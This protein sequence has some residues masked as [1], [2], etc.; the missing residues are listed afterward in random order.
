MRIGIDAR[1]LNR[2]HLRG[3]G[4][5]VKDLLA[6]ADLQ[7]RQ[8]WRLYGDRPDQP[9]HRPDV[10]DLSASLFETRGYRFRWWEQAGLPRAARR[11]RVEVLH[12]TGTTLPWWQPVP[13]VV[14]LHDTVP[15]VSESAG[16]PGWYLWQVLPRAYRKCAAVITISENSRRDILALW[17]DLEP[18]LL[19]IPHGID[20]RYLTE[21]SVALPAEL[22]QLGIRSPYLVYLGGTIPRKRLDWAVQVLSKLPD[23]R[24]QLVVCGVDATSKAQVL[25]AIPEAVRERVLVT[26]FIGEDAMPPLLRHGVALLY[27]T[28]Y[29][30]FGFPAIE[31]QAVGT[32]VLFSRVGSLTELEGPGA[33]VLPT[34]DLDAWVQTCDELLSQ[35]RDA[36]VQNEAA[37][38]WAGRFS[39][40]E[41]ARRHLAVY[42]EAARGTAVRQEYS[43]AASGRAAEAAVVSRS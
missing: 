39:W 33:H 3:M 2:E 8:Q 4:R 7:Q 20:P 11:D 30:G 15:W 41:S 32:P 25:A 38:R 12:C 40:T 26:P 5:Y 42:A 27:P 22:Q 31:A 28:L 21:A 14:T 17:P 18:K 16:Q 13:T 9:L 6:A 23:E 19:V 37:R 35:R 36:L 1:C 34:D 29:E 43:L 24:L 10:A